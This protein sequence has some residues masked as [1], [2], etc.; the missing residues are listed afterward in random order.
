MAVVMSSDFFYSDGENI[1]L[2]ETKYF[3]AKIPGQARNDRRVCSG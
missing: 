1:L 3:N 2:L